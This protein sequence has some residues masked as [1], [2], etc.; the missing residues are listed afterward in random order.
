MPWGWEPQQIT[1]ASLKPPASSLS[2]MLGTNAASLQGFCLDR[3]R[4]EVLEMRGRTLSSLKLRFSAPRHG[5]GAELPGVWLHSFPW[6]QQRPGGLCGQRRRWT[7]V[8]SKE[9]LSSGLAVG[10]PRLRQAPSSRLHRDE[11]WPA[12]SPAQPPFLT[13][14]QDIDSYNIKF[15]ESQLWRGQLLP[16]FAWRKVGYA[17]FRGWH[18]PYPPKETP[19]EVLA[20]EERR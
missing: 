14:E 1:E 20:W 19:A 12:P 18:P 6:D 10:V 3:N 5:S 7:A 16:P 4:R 15:K 2:G 8:A 17:A 13:R 9:N 11:P